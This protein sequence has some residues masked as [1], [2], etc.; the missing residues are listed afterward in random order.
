ML[1]PKSNALQEN[2]RPKSFIN[3]DA[4]ILNE[5]LENQM[6]VWFNR[7]LKPIWFTILTELKRKI[8]WWF[9]VSPQMQ[10]KKFLTKFHSIP[11]KNSQQTRNR[12]GFL[13]LIKGIYQN[14]PLTSYLMVK[15]NAFPLVLRT[16]QRCQFSLLL[17][18]IEPE[19]LARATK[20]KKEIKGIT[21]GKEVKLSWLRDVIIC[22]KDP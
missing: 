14:W 6:H 11:N 7:L 2:Y 17:I 21:I 15:K 18:N 12:G 3:T 22:T 10:E 19:D 9:P 20:R 1:Y 4:K 13:N 5:M 8:L 16:R